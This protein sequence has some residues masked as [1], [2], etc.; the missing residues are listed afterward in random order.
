MPTLSIFFGITIRMYWQDHA[1]PH[2]HAFYSGDEATF[3]VNPEGHIS[4]KF[5]ERAIRL[6]EEWTRLHREEL[7]F[8]W[9]LLSRNQSAVKIEGLK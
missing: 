8:N 5:Q 9:N 7:L 1:R 2:F 4:G 3:S 6:V